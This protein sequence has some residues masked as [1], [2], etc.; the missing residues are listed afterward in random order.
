MRRMVS[1]A[2][3]MES[4]WALV[5]ISPASTTRPV[6]VNVSAATRLRGSCRKRASRIA[7]EI[8]SATLSGW[9]SETD[10]EVKRKS[11]AISINSCGGSAF[12]R[13]P[14]PVGAMANALAEFFNVALQVA[15]LT[16]RPVDFNASCLAFLFRASAVVAGWAGWGGGLA[17]VL[18]VRQ[19]PAALLRACGAGR[20]F[21]RRGARR[22]GP[23]RP[24]GGRT[25]APV[26]GRAAA[27]P[28]GGGGP[29]GEGRGWGVGARRPCRL[30]GG[31]CVEQAYAAGR[32][33]VYLTPHQGCFELS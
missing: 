17:G 27:P 1:R 11:F 28:P 7:S 2:T 4:T 30:E 22:R 19:V 33:I 24:H 13:C 8:W 9:P 31:A 18:C 32:G 23:C 3:C 14:D 15:H 20:L 21:V 29:R 25:A 6:L 12:G 16:Q 5:L 10:S 26:A